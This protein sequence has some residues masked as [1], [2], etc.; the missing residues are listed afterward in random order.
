MAEFLTREGIVDHIGR[1][2]KEAEKEIV[3]ISPYINAD[4]D[5]KKLIE[6]T[7]RAVT[8]HVIYG[9]REKLKQNEREFFD[10]RSV[11]LS[12]RKDLHAKCYLNEKEAI[13][14]SMNLYEYSQ[15]YNDEMGILVSREDDRE[16]Y[17]AIHKQAMEWKEDS[18]SVDA[19]ASGRRNA[20][21]ARTRKEATQTVD[22]PL[23]GFCIRCKDDVPANL[24]KPHCSNCYSIWNKFKNKKFEEKYCHICGSKHT[25]TLAEPLCLTCY[26]ELEDVREFIAF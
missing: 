23:K 20:R 16:L 25:T 17:E 1:I 15:L 9:K 26:R 21:A 22:A 19:P 12:Y 6:D 3:L 13:L 18:S 10:Q 11:K 4:N 2:I 5:T 24:T 14:T 8:I 7:T